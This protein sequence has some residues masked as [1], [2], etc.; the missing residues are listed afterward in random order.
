MEEV[1][2]ENGREL[3]VDRDRVALEVKK[4]RL[5]HQLTQRQLGE[6]WGL[7]RYTIIRVENAQNLSWEIAYK[8]MARL[9]D[10]MREEGGV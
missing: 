9:T 6:K 4:Y 3:E 8:I 2:K 10:T 5:R 1:F 7:S